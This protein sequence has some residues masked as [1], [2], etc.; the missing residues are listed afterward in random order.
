MRYIALPNAK[1]ESRK[2]KQPKNFKIVDALE[3]AIVEGV[4]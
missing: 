3:K 4:I 2:A 1:P